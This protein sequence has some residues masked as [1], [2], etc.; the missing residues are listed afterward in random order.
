[1][2]ILKNASKFEILNKDEL[3]VTDNFNPVI[4][5]ITRAARTCYQSES[6][7][8][9]NDINDSILVK[10]LIKKKHESMIEFGGIMI[11]RFS[12][13]SRAFS[14]ELVRHRIASY[15]QKSTRYVDDSDFNIIIPP[16]KDENETVLKIW[17]P[18]TDQTG[19]EQDISLKKWLEMNEKVYRSLRTNGWK[20]EEARQVLP[21]GIETEIVISAN[22]REW[23]HIFKMRCD[24]SAH[25]EIR[26]V[27]LDLL[28]W[29]QEN[30][31]IIFDDF[32]I[33]DS[34]LEKRSYAKGI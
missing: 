18:M 3:T 13:I 30:I 8:G 27:M 23:R 14:H 10:N 29:C 5:K 12:D 20:K 22:L 32:E 4:Y 7:E 24:K 16:N 17:Y 15:A 9:V 26:K 6:N 21:I 31:P 28:A 11:V 19:V 2:N 25:W 33:I 34:V 1:M